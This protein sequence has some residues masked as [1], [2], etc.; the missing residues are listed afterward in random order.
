MLLGHWVHMHGLLI[1][2]APPCVLTAVNFNCIFLF[3]KAR[4][5]DFRAEEN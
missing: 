3:V 4:Y 5:Y 1:L 2:K